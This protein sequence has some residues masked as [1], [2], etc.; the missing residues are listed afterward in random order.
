MQS[1]A[2][3]FVVAGIRK[4]LFKVGNRQF[5]A[6]AV[7]YKAVSLSPVASSAHRSYDNSFAVEPGATRGM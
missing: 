6:R 3:R 4:N 7:L 2:G 5:G 1:R